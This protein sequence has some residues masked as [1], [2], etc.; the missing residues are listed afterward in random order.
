MLT[1]LKNLIQILK[2]AR[3]AEPGFKNWLLANK[4]P[5]SIGLGLVTAYV[6]KTGC[7][8]LEQYCPIIDKA[9]VA[10]TGYLAGAGIMKSDSFHREQ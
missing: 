3:S 4:A 8:G 1:K 10:A 6:G 7:V 5:L 9:L 2:F